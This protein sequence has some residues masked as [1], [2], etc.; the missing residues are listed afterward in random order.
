MKEKIQFWKVEELFDLSD[1]V[2]FISGIGGIGGILAE[3]FAR[4]GSK[5]ILADIN[6]QA[7]HKIKKKITE[8]GFNAETYKMDVTQKKS[9]SNV[10]KKI[11]KNY[12]VIDIFI[13]TSGI[14]INEKAIN[15]D[16]ED[17]DRIININ[18]KGTILC[19][20]LV[21]RLM[22]KQGRGKIIN[23][24]SIGGHITHTLRSMP[25]GASKAGVHQVTR[26]FAAELA[27]YGINVNSIAPT[28][29]NTAMTAGKDEL[30]YQNIYNLTPFGRMCEPEELIGTTIFLATESSNFITG[31]TIF[32]D[33]GWSISKAL[34]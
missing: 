18:L 30:Y 21:G 24:G 8:L 5:I 28:W 34:Y 9:I 33:G 14:A 29:V 31:Q 17:I 13:N 20:Q 27:E 2:T 6:E 12:N 10:L 11:L 23:I 19:N 16:E 3:A 25:Y 22:S 7:L 26:S 4:N 32:V 15:F 1:K